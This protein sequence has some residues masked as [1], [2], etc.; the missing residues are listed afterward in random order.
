MS[1]RIASISG[2]VTA[3]GTALALV[4]VTTGC[5]G[6]SDTRKSDALKGLPIAETY[7]VPPAGRVASAAQPA[8]DGDAPTD[9]TPVWLIER[10]ATGARAVELSLRGPTARV[11]SVVRLRG[12]FGG[13][14]TFDVGHWRP[15]TAAAHMFAMQ[16]RPRGVS[17]TVIGLTGPNRVVASG[18][19]ALPAPVSG[20]KRELSIATWSGRRPDLFVIDRGTGDER[21]QLTIFSGESTFRRP[22]Y[23]AKLPFV[24][25][26]AGWGLDVGQVD[27]PVPDLLLTRRSGAGGPPVPQAQVHV[28]TGQ[29]AFAG[30]TAENVIRL[31]GDLPDRYHFVFGVWRARVSVM[32]VDL[33]RRKD[34]EI[35]VVPVVAT[36]RGF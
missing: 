31:P 23:R 32:G 33:R 7:S 13:G 28:L 8:T 15:E 16:R 25:L 27:P 6:A 22:L 21:I 29:S 14:T 26:G 11:V 1:S 34:E 30:L 18:T 17:V 3:V 12:R 10:R 35:Q 24:G 19:A 5:G 36:P 20:T 2:V 4:L 9:N